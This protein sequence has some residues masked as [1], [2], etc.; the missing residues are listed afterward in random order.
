MANLNITVFWNETFCTSSIIDRN[1]RFGATC[2]LSLLD[3][4]ICWMGKVVGELNWLRAIIYCRSVMNL[5]FSAPYTLRYTSCGIVVLC[6][7]LV[8]M[9][10]TAVLFGS[11][12]AVWT[13]E[14][15]EISFWMWNLLIMQGR[16]LCI[17]SLSSSA[18]QRKFCNKSCFSDARECR[19]SSVCVATG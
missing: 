8:H 15:L 9:V 2:Y 4:L 7:W 19:N 18:T 10:T 14:V 16:Y 6:P 12:V 1:W 5:S 3:G 11:Y 13:G 17:E